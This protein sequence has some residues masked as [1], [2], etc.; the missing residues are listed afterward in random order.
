M[1]GTEAQAIQKR[2]IAQCVSFLTTC[3]WVLQDM[4][5]YA[6]HIRVATTE[7]P[8]EPAFGLQLT[9]VPRFAAYPGPVF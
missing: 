3:R 4:P 7:I 9:Y 2:S 1:I 8:E 6:P 5:L